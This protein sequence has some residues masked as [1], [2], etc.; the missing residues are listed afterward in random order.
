MITLEYD[1]LSET[2]PE[3][4]EL[5]NNISLALG[6]PVY[7]FGSRYILGP[8]YERGDTDVLVDATDIS[9][10]F[11]EHTPSDSCIE[12]V[13]L[14]GYRPHISPGYAGHHI[15]SYRNGDINLVLMTDRWE[16]IARAACVELCR[17]QGITDKETRREIHKLIADVERV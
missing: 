9:E 11:G 7:P 1:Q 5:L 15:S 14:M 13:L 6:K 4:C 8:D 3:Y 16:F 10:L 17:T 12:K 2:D